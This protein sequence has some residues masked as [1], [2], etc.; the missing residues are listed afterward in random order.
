MIFGNEV[1][2]ATHIIQRSQFQKTNDYN[3]VSAEINRMIEHEIAAPFLKDA[4]V[5]D[6]VHFIGCSTGLTDEDT[7]I[8]LR[9]V[10]VKLEVQE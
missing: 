3:A 5:G 1:L 6:T 10:P 8:P 4:E 9:L 7:L 2:D